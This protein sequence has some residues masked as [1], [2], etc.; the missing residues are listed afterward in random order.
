MFKLLAIEL[1]KIFK[2]PRTYIAFAVITV[3][4]LLVQI[5]LKFGGEEYVDL[6]MT[7]AKETFDIAI[8]AWSL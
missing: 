5:A 7:G 1:Y 4:I 8:L 2:R 3:I 6:M